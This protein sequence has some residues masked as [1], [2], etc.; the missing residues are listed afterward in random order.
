ML[1]GRDIYEALIK[2]IQKAMGKIVSGIASVYNQALTGAFYF[3]I[4]I[5]LMIHIKDSCRWL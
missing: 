1:V 4:I 5:I 3:L 2:D